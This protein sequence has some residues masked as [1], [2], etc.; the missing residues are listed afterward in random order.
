[1]KI[2]STSSGGA[3]NGH[4]GPTPKGTGNGVTTHTQR[5]EELV[6]L[7]VQ[8]LQDMGLSESAQML[9]RES[10]HSLESPIVSDFRAGVLAGN[11]EA[12]TRLLPMLDIKA[13]DLQTVKFLISEQ[14]YLEQLEAGDTQSALSVLRHELGAMCSDT[15]RVH[16][17]ASFMMCADADT[18]KSRAQ[19]TGAEGASR[20]TLLNQLQHFIPSAMMIP[21]HRLN[22]L[23]DQAIELQKNNCLY[24]NVDDEPSSLYVDHCCS[25]NQ[26]PCSTTHIFD[27]HADEVW[28]LAFSHDGKYLASA[29]KDMT[30]AIWN[31]ETWSLVHVLD[32][33]DSAISY[34][35][36]SPD[37]S[38][39]L[40]GSNDNSLRVW[41]PKT[42]ECRNTFA[43]HTN[44]VTAC[45]W[46]PDSKRFVSGSIDKHIF[47]WNVE[48]NVLHRWSGV[49][50][51]DL[52]VSKDGAIMLAISEKTIRMYDLS[53]Q[54]EVGVL[55]ETDSITSVLIADDCRHVLVNL[56]LQEVHLWDM[57]EKRLVRKFVGHKQGR[58]VIRSCFGGLHEN[59]VLSGSE[60]SKIYVWHREQGVLIEKLEGHSASVNCVSWNSKRNMFASASDDHTIRVW[61]LASD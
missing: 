14:K 22:V 25:R 51:T 50:V 9:Q 27:V 28:F 33:H 17:L 32:G 38:L 11:W 48:G 20:T 53:D 8:S 21:Q 42:G 12:V 43:R 4:S 24:H 6:R 54:S 19:W 58:F 59:F 41:C 60:D 31:V 29:S 15:Q 44:T 18:L 56:S 1:M 52:A 34:L 55:P 30:A 45:A 3:A 37:D 40:T 2:N 35:A 13:A 49:R 26:F 7:M 36:W 46:L 47:L 39:L 61:G 23:L 10:G 5:E 16:L 57:I